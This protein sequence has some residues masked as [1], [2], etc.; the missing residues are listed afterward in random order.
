MFPEIWHR[1]IFLFGLISL[2]SG[3]LFGS[4][5][6]SIP[7]IILIG[8]WLIESDLSKKIKILFRDKFF[9]ILS[10]LFLLHI[11]G[12]AYTSDVQSGLNDLKT[13][14]PI[15]VLAVIFLSTKPLNMK[16]F[17]LLF[18]FF[19]LS[20]LV[21]S[22]W[23]YLVYAG[24]SNKKIIDIRDASVFM[25]H[26][27]FS[28]IISFTVIGLSYF[29]KSNTNRL[30][31]ILTILWLLFFMYK[32]QMA[33]GIIL[34]I[35][36]GLCLLVFY[37]FKM[38]N[39]YVNISIC[40]FLI[41]LS[42]LTYNKINSDLLMYNKNPPSNNNILLTQTINHNNY[43]QDTLF[44]LAENGNL[45][46]I[47]INDYELQKEWLKRS[48]LPYEG[49]D[50]NGNNLRFTILR[51]IASKGFTKDSLG[52]S[53]LNAQDILNIENGTSNFKY[54]MSSGLMNKWRELVWEFVKYKR[55]ENPSG[56]TLTMRLE[57]WGTSLYIIK[58]NYLFGV[59]TGDIGQ[60]FT[61]AYNDTNS[62]LS[63]EWRLR[64][65][66]Q[67][68]AFTVAFGLFGL[69]LF[70]F[71]IFYPIVTLKHKL[72]FL[73]WPFI[74]ILLLSFF[75]EDTLESQAGVTFF[76]LFNTLFIWLASSNKQLDK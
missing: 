30:I 8:N 65:H 68:L 42:Y 63:K 47:N 41:G 12:M 75:T 53:N 5:L 74:M 25:S 20:V 23:C 27:R 67:Y 37:L 48:K 34:L 26:I 7:Q 52:I 39:L 14:V 61:K 72:H 10:S 60:S 17:V 22:I 66:N 29:I 49:N 21:S 18:Q 76:A 57:F 50:N 2:A 55:N 31:S 51:Y 64:C 69:I 28:L 54:S 36:V 73:Y 35:I 45:I 11:L 58:Q 62:K 24:L 44:N 33:T 71:Y 9:W 46:T 13:K 40:L 4:A 59:G 43:L 3:L 38:K 6:T 16:E 56:H 32:F 15:P 1:R 19:F 70:L